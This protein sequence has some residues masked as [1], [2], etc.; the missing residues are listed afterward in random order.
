[1]QTRKSGTSMAAPHVAGIVALLLE[2]E[3]GL[4]AGQIA[5]LLKATSDQPTGIVGFD[6]AWGFGRV[7][8]LR[9][10]ALLRNPNQPGLGAGI[11]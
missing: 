6:N 4:S 2:E 3:P 11:V 5:N 7:N 10:L 1:M 9:A 8:A